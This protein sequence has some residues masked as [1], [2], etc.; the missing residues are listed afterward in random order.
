VKISCATLE[1]TADDHF[2]QIDTGT[3][4]IDGVWITATDPAAIEKLIGALVVCGAL[5]R[6]S[7]AVSA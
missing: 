6:D 4:G 2:E 1:V 7:R 3:I 5:L